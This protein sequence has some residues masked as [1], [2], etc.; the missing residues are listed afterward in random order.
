MA[1][2]KPK[3]I[4]LYAARDLRFHACSCCEKDREPG[5]FVI[6]EGS[7]GFLVKPTRHQQKEL[8]RRNQG[9]PEGSSERFALVNLEGRPRYLRRCD[10]LSEKQY[11]ARRQ[12]R[13]DR[14]KALRKE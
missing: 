10:V 8:D 11:E 12:R 14:L 1:K 5:P 7:E 6:P 3:R 13:K 4:K 2:G 9:L